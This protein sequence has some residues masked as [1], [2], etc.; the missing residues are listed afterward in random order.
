MSLSG[1]FSKKKPDVKEQ[2]KVQD[3]ALRHT[4]RDLDRD[5]R[6]LERREKQL[7]L[8]IKK[9]AK[10][11]KNTEGVK[12]LA[13]QLVALRKQKTRSMTANSQIT[14]IRMQGKTMTSNVKM[15]E[16]MAST[17]RAM[18]NMNDQL[19]PQQV[20]QIMQE[21][22]KESAKMDMSEEMINDTLDDILTESG[23]ESEENSIVNRILD[24]I[25]IE[26]GGQ[27]SKAPAP[28]RSKVGEASRVNQK[29]LDDE[30]E[31]IEKQ[32]AR[33]KAE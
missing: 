28:S 16:A 20:G 4:Q 31:E 25:G 8:D 27:I 24:E 18:H 22:S 14:G 2:I 15:S 19:S 21:F 10:D 23:D 30:A 29:S 11:G 13:K 1:L 33:L 26:V 12:I 3:K 32:L 9:M 5:R 6:E 17:T 7:E